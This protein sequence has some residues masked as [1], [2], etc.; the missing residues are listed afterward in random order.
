MGCPLAVETKQHVGGSIE[1]IIGHQ[2]KSYTASPSEMRKTAFISGSTIPIR[3]VK[4]PAGRLKRRKILS[5]E[6]DRIH[7]P[8][9]A[10]VH[11]R[12]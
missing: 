4:S 5:F 2:A 1:F 10:H 3:P 8:S 11:P 7:K 6:L 12:K 9:G